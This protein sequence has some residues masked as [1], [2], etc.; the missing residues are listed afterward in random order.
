MR[1]LLVDI[2]AGRGDGVVGERLRQGPLVDDRAARDVDDAAVLPELFKDVGID[3]VV[4]TG[5]GAHRN[6]Q[7]AAPIGERREIRKITI[8]H[9]SLA[10]AEIAD[11]GL[12]GGHAGRDLAADLA[13]PVDA[14]LA[15]GH[16]GL[17]PHHRRRFRGRPVPA[18]HIIVG[19]QQTP[20]RRQHQGDR[21]IG[22]RGRVRPGT[23]ADHD[24]AG[25]GGLK[26]DAVITGAVTDDRAELRHHVHH[27][28]GK[29]RSTRRDHGTDAGKVIRRKHLVRRLAGGIHQFKTLADAQHQRLGE[30]RKDQDF[31][32]HRRI[33][34]G[35]VRDALTSGTAPSPRRLL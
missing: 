19:H 13:H 31:F 32:G 17:R 6:H 11:L 20:R 10:A 2:E 30:A 5:A 12:E 33:P 7:Y 16:T 4:G 23:M 15:T 25:I 35:C 26:V 9:V 18:S 14:D 8:G 28:A 27:L 1:L 24:L 34:G 3:D 22:H 29:R 21:D